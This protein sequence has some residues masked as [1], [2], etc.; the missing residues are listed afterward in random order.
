MSYY[1]TYLYY[2][3]LLLLSITTFVLF[4]YSFIQ[5]FPLI[6]HPSVPSTPLSLILTM[7]DYFIFS[8]IKTLH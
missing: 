6:S 3:S 7:E 2:T 1:I 4:H 5:V 8:N